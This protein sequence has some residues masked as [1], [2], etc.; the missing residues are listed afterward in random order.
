MS[1][2]LKID[3]RYGNPSPLDNKREN[4]IDI[5]ELINSIYE[6]SMV[7]LDKAIYDEQDMKTAALATLFAG[8]RINTSGDLF[9]RGTTGKG[10]STLVYAFPYLLDEVK[11]ENIALYPGD[12]DA[13]NKEIVGGAITINKHVKR[14]DERTGETEEYT[15]EETRIIKGILSKN[16][17]FLVKNEANRMSLDAQNAALDILEFGMYVNSNGANKVT[18]IVSSMSVSNAPNLLEGTRPEFAHMVSRHTA[19]G[20]MGFQTSKKNQELIKLGV[21]LKPTFKSSSPE[22]E[23]NDPNVFFSTFSLRQLRMGRE[24]VQQVVLP[25]RGSFGKDDI[26]RMQDSTINLFKERLKVEDG[27]LGRQTMNMAKALALLRGHMTI[28]RQDYQTALEYKIG[29]SVAGLYKGSDE[30][31]NELAENITRTVI[32]A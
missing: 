31:G 24:A 9:V 25:S 32:E 3:A 28:S 7:Q 10:K 8:N 12:P 11:P 19:G 5:P 21:E 20:F 27:R 6:D 30:E 22:D 2:T 13:D 4:R 18:D 14:R 17:L 16:T 26:I 23:R 15:E 29:A 1:E